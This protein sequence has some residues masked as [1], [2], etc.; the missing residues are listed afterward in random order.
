MKKLLLILNLSLLSTFAFAQLTP[1]FFAS[2]TKKIT[3]DHEG[4]DREFIVFNPPTAQRKFKAPVVFMFHGT[5]G[6]GLKFYKISQWKEKALDEGFIAVFPSSLAYKICE[7]GSAPKTTTKW[8]TPNINSVLC[9]PKAYLADDQAF[10]QKM[11]SFLEN[12]Y[13]VDSKRIYASGFS[14]GNGFVQQLLI[15]NSHLIAAAA[16][17]GSLRITESPTQNVPFYSTMGSKDPKALEKL[18]LTEFPVSEKYLDIPEIKELL[19]DS[20]NNLGLKNEYTSTT[21]RRSFHAVYSVDL[22]LEDKN[23]EL[24]MLVLDELTHQYPNGKNYP[25]KMVDI[26]WPF[27]SRFSK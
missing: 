24:N 26:L 12:N 16:G 3:I 11:V 15:H 18:G 17:N 27:F 7:E 23:S 19:A 14:N 22:Q 10:F 5:S 13:R 2:Y 6:N 20:L 1:E 21:R 8:V 9:D 4:Y 25:L